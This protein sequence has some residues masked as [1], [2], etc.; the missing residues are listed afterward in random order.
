MSAMT[1]R[2]VK[3]EAQDGARSDSGAQGA[4]CAPATIVRNTT[5]TR[6]SLS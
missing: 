4:Q 6:S 3:R 2:R 1:G 5:E